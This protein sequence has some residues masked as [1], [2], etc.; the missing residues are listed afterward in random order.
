VIRGPAMPPRS[1]LRVAVVLVLSLWVARAPAEIVNRIIAT[2][3]GEPVTELE[4][5]KYAQDKGNTGASGAVVLDALITDRLL[6][7]EIKAQGIEARP[8]EI[9][10]YIEEIRTRNG[11]DEDQFVRAL[12]GQGMT[13]ETYRARVKA[14]IEKAQLVNR[15]IRGR[16]NVS[17]EE[18]ERHYK[19]HLSDYAIAEQVQ[20]RA[21]FFTLPADASQDEV[22]HERQKAEEVRK[23]AADGRDFGKLAAQFSEGPGADKGGEL[24]TFSHGQM[25]SELDA[26]AFSLKAG[27]VSDV[28]RTD[29][30]FCI[31]RVDKR[32]DEGHRPLEEVKD[33]IRESLYNDALEERFENWLSRELRERHHVEVVR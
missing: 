18:V 32:I 29:E 8:E 3:D 9:D 31:L 33:K 12:Q 2:I 30:G 11:M 27:Q 21:I 17:P 28:I 22:E 14:E 5:Q 1:V 20:V 16:V 23:M 10:R 19:A 26:A 24:G 4:Y 25:E 13:M 6:E 7:K 15:E